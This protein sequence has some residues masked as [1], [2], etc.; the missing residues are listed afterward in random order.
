MYDPEST[1]F[2][3]RIVLCC[4]VDLAEDDRTPA[5]S[6]T[7]RG[8]ARELLEATDETAFKTVSEADVTRALKRLVEADL[9]VEDGSGDQ[10][11][12]GK[13]RPRYGL[14]VGTEEL[15]AELRNDERVASLLKHRN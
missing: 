10:S 12:V 14:N 5:D 2:I 1:T 7:V 15:R 9:L 8:M 13:G 11:P 4:L 3:E 6:S